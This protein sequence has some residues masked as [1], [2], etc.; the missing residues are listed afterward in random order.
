ML[1]KNGNA[2]EKIRTRIAAATQRSKI[3]T[4]SFL[5]AN[6]LDSPETFIKTSESA[7]PQQFA[8]IRLDKSCAIQNSVPH[9]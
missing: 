5:F 3:R 2:A 4:L 1:L 9:L 8:Y 6:V 7:K